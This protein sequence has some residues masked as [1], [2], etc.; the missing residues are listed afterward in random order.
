MGCFSDCKTEAD[1]PVIKAAVTD[2]ASKAVSAEPATVKAETAKEELKV[3]NKE[4]EET[5]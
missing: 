5:V 3:E 2:S 4:K 1:K